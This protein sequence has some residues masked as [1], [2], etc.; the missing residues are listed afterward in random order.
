LAVYYLVNKNCGKSLT[1]PFIESRFTP[2]AVE[3]EIADAR[4]FRE[5]CIS[6][7]VPLTLS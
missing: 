5:V 1:T 4:M 3:A 6:L 2:E 7:A